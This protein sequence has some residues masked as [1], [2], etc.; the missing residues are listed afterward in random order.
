MR[1]FGG[2]LKELRKEKG[3][4]QEE[5]AKKLQI[6]KSSIGM[7][8]TNKRIPEVRTLES[9]ADYFNVDMDYLMG[10]T[11]TRRIYNYD[12]YTENRQNTISFLS[13][14]VLKLR[15]LDEDDLDEVMAL[16]N[17]KLSKAKYNE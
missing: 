10:N 16:V 13:Q 17:H 5:L 2:R 15:K 3:L 11:D 14:Y 9:I 7:Y 1:S 8:E 4:T 6:A 12:F